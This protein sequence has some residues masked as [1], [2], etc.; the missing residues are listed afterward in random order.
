MEPKCELGAIA[1]K[2]NINSKNLTNFSNN[3]P[4]A[5]IPVLRA[6]SLISL[7]MIVVWASGITSEEA[8]EVKSLFNDIVS[9][10][11]TYI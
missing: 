8:M 3:A 4:D 5:P 2:L 9:S 1:I 6:A 11:Y 10:K 7:G